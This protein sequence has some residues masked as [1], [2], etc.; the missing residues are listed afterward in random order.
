MLTNSIKYPDRE[1]LTAK[2]PADTS[3]V[4][5]FEAELQLII[6]L[7]YLN[8]KER[9]R[10]N[11]TCF[12]L[13]VPLMLRT[14]TAAQRKAEGIET[15]EREIANLMEIFYFHPLNSSLLDKASASPGP[16]HAFTSN[17]PVLQ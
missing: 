6:W 5:S 10:K 12:V 9:K 16:I 13:N 11:S 14:I 2:K 15:Q 3:V 4:F 1:G 7:E 8:K 17:S